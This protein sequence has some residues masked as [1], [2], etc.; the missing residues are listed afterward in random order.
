MG[1]VQEPRKGYTLGYL[2][3]PS[4]RTLGFDMNILASRYFILEK[5]MFL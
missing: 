2:V 4:N 3:S 1:I 5:V